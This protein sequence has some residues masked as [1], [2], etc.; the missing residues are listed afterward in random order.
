MCAFLG[1]MCKNMALI[2]PH[3]IQGSPMLLLSVLFSP[4]LGVTDRGLGVLKLC[5]LLLDSNSYLTKPISF[6]FL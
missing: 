6:V 3:Q 4:I 2:A 5:A 1:C